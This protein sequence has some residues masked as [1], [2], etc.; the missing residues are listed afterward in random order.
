MDGPKDYHTKWGS[1]DRERQ[2]PYHLYVE[3]KEHNINEF[4]K[5]N[6]HRHRKKTCGYQR[7]EWGRA[8]LGVW[9]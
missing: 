5:R 1:S 4:R 3:S 9:D 7:V 2:I 6:T 8:R